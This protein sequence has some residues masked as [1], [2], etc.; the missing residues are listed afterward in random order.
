MVKAPVDMAFFT[1]Y[2]TVQLL[3][4]LPV[5]GIDAAVANHFV[6]LFGDMLDKPPYEF[7]DRA[8]KVTPDVF[9]GGLGVATV[10]LGIDIEPVLMLPVASG[11]YLFERGADK[12]FHFI[13]ECG[14]ESIAEESIV[15]VVHGAPNA[16]VTEFTLGDEAV[17]M[18]VPFQVP[19]E[20][21]QDHDKAGG[22]VHGFILEKS[23]EIFVNGKNT[24]SVCDIDELKR[25]G[26]SAFHG[27][28]IA[29]GGAETAVAT[30]RN[31]PKLSTVRTAIHGTPKRRVTAMDHFTTFS[32]TES[33][34]CYV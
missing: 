25:H 14:T 22:E 9:N 26:G 15:E 29:A 20:C 6:M 24:M 27:I 4:N 18:G 5:A 19:A 10:R 31:K 34:G 30:E 7:H 17:D 12:G 13:K 33:R 23:P 8:A 11:L 32:T 21:V 28:F 2:G 1:G 16:V 3:V